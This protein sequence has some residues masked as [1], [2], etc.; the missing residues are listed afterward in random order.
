MTQGDRPTGLTK[1]AGWEIGVRRTLPVERDVLWRRLTGADGLALWLGPGAELPANR[2][3]GWRGS[4]GST[5]ALRSLETG[6]L[7]RLTWHPTEWA[8]PSTLQ[9]RLFEAR[10][11]TTISFHHERLTSADRREEMRT[12]WAGVIDRLAAMG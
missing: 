11:G 1:D 7:I 2:G 5:G 8:E 10:T 9:I 6:K 4:D 12:H 3:D